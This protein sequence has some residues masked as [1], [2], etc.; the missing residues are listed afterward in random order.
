MTV[1]R[2]HAWW[3]ALLML[4]AVFLS[5]N[6]L[7]QALPPAPGSAAALDSLRESLANTTDLETLVAEKFA[8]APLTRQQSEEAAAMLWEWKLKRLREER[9]Q[10]WGAK[11]ITIGEKTMRFEYRVFGEKPA[12]GRSLFISM[13][14]GGQTSKQVNDQQ[15]RNQISLYRPKEGVYIAPRA[16]TDNW[17]LWHEPHIDAMFDRLIEDAIAFEDVNPDRVY[18]MGYSAGGDGVYQL[19][20]RMADRWAS[21]AMMAGHPNEAQPLGLR[22]VPFTIHMGE[23]DGAYDR[24]KIAKEWGEK[25]DKLRTDDPDGYE[26][27]VQIHKG[28]GHWMNRADAVAVGW[29]AEHT[30]TP[31]P[32]RVVWHQDDVVSPRLYWLVM[33]PDDRQAGAGLVGAVDG[34]RITIKSDNLKRVTLLLADGLGGNLDLD[35]EIEV[36]WGGH[37]VFHG[38]ADR[39][40]GGLVKSLQER[41]DPRAFYPARVEVRID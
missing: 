12:G 1:S 20:P 5:R 30:R 40:I 35:R 17:N 26:H 21:A 23:L 34:Q 14:G 13:H 3:I 39:T 33:A 31:M 19:T 9:K 11:S 16:P 29:M 4:G 7:A 15:W 6:A 25:L 2:T 28:M 27:A 22:N 32:S 38:R 36:S 18:L 24:N 41:S 37:T 10:E 8:A